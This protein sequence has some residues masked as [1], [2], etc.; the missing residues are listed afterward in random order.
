MSA[1]ETTKPMAF[2]TAALDQGLAKAM[3]LVELTSA[4]SMKNAEAMMAAGSAAAKGAETLAAALLG[5][6]KS[7]LETQLSAAA[8]FA[9]VKSPQELVALQS[10][11]ARQSLEAYT[12]QVRSVSELLNAAF[13]STAAPLKA[14]FDSVV[15]E[16]GN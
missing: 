9:K 3:S 12:A 14:R 16:V 11:L 7:A 13:K 6:G 8:A 15:S 2:Q 4:T 5:H 1:A 10:T